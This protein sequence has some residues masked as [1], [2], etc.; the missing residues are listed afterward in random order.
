MTV[1]IKPITREQLEKVLVEAG[2]PVV[3]NKV[4]RSDLKKMVAPKP[5]EEKKNGN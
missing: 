2:I 4:K 5:K 1:H 3:D